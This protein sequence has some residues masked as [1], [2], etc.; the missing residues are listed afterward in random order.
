M[1]WYITGATGLIG[2]P[3]VSRLA[4][5]GHQVVALSRSAEAHF[6]SRGKDGVI[7]RNYD[8]ATGYPSATLPRPYGAAGLIALGSRISKSTN[9][10]EVR[11]QLGLDTLGHLSL[12]DFLGPNL[13]YILYASSCTVYGAPQY[14]PVP[15]TAP[16]APKNVYAL[17]KVASEL[18]LQQ[19][20]RC[21]HIPVTILRIS[22]VYGPGASLQAAMYQFLNL[23][24]S[25]ARP[26]ITCD[27]ETFR[28]YC[29]VDDVIQ[30]MEAAIARRS[31][32]VFNIGGG[33]PISMMRLAHA[34]LAAAG[35][36]LEPEVYVE[37]PGTS[38]W[39][40]ISRART[41]LNYAPKVHLEDGVL[42]EFR[43]LWGVGSQS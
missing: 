20:Q 1:I 9:L 4:E 41:H 32:G 12:V 26:R 8:L 34:C 24:R 17:C 18:M 42:S 31:C 36:G 5:S 37:H 27:P 35:S 28:D 10:G 3:L 21:W 23:A 2:K 7:A 38:M 19:I 14:F 29:H 30:A 39:L 33:E 15:D 25:G 13:E 22:Q 11:S 6:A 43:R 40:D 16:L